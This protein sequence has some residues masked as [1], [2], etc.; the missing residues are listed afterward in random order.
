MDMV[1][2]FQTEP[3]GVALPFPGLAG[4]HRPDHSRT[5]VTGAVYHTWGFPSKL[6][7]QSPQDFWLAV[8]PTLRST[9]WDLLYLV[10]R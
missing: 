3:R 2:E 1:P 6:N 9:L 4:F 10:C 8:T 5:D 7:Y